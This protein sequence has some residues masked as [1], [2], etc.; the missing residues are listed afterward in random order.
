MALE[1][2][3]ERVQ[4]DENVIEEDQAHDEFRCSC[5]VYQRPCESVA[6]RFDILF[7]FSNESSDYSEY[8][9]DGL[10]T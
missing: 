10:S 9:I 2:P 6:F 7:E 8:A 3:R 5:H 4:K 1:A